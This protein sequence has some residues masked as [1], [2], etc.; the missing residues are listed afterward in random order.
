M[1]G[2]CSIVPRDVLLRLSQDRRLSDEV[3]DDLLRTAA[4][5]AEVRKLRE[6]NRKLTRVAQSTNAGLTA[7][8]P[9]PTSVLVFNCS[10]TETLPGNPVA[11]PGNSADATISTA[12]AETKELVNF[13]ETVFGRSSIDDAGLSLVSS[14]HFGIEHNNAYWNG[15]QM[16]YGDGDGRIFSG[17]V[18]APDVIGHENTHGVIQY[19]LQLV[20]RNEPG[21][22]NESL[23]D[24]FGSMFRQ[25]RKQQSVVDADWLIG[26][27]I[28]GA[29]AKSRGLTCLRDMANPGAAHC[30]A[31][32]PKHYS[33]YVPGMDPHY[34]SGIPNHAFHRAAMA[35]GGFSWETVGQIW[36]KAMTGYGAS[37]NLK[38]RAFADRTR[39]VAAELFPDTAGVATAVDDAWVQVGL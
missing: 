23:A 30:L 1:C 2:C 22:L 9:G 11:K 29:E 39:K 14:V 7:V 10:G 27:E 37:P 19:S 35:I 34:S 33:D 20:Y 3:R 28:V 36:Y 13:Y 31:P 38:M 17:F 18:N 24:V 5:D 4:M 6:Q 26:R 32:Q 25:W 16:I 8:L 12:Y 15:S 21:G